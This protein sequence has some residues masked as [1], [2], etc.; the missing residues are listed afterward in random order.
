MAK[1]LHVQASPRGE[2]SAS[3]AVAK[4]FLAAYQK[5]NP[6]DTVETLDIWHTDLPE[7]DGEALNAKYAV[8]TGQDFTPGQQT[9]WNVV[10][11]MAE[12]FKSADKLIFSLP[13]WNFGIPYRLKQYFDVIAQPGLLFGFAPDKGYFGLV[14]GK[15]AVAI[16]ASGGLYAPGSG[17][18]AF[19]LQSKY[20]KLFL[21][22]VGVS[23]VKDIFVG[24]TA[25][26][27]DAV[28]TGKLQA[29]EVAV[30]F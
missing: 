30:A 10:T 3:T 28:A 7:F 18:E 16:Y 23:D 4:E 25:M 29:V 20:L 11:T 13:M 1:I 27:K 21:G 5:N 26:N 17:A 15:K 9:A 22:F 14:T 19:D 24:G 8:M 12:H 2:R 6:G